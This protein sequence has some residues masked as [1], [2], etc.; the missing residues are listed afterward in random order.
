MVAL[1]VGVLAS[2]EE[3]VGVAEPDRGGDGEE[4]NDGEDNDWDWDPDPETDSANVFACPAGA[5]FRTGAAGAGCEG[6][7]GWR[8][9]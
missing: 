5:S 1:A 6:G 4:T 9:R 2:A 3:A 8:S 7:F